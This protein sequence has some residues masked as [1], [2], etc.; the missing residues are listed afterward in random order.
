VGSSENPGARG[1][2]PPV[3]PT[4]FYVSEII[5]D[6]FIIVPGHERRLHDV[7]DDCRVRDVVPRRSIKR[8]ATIA[9][10]I[11]RDLIRF[12]DSVNSGRRAVL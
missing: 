10:D 12:A 5:L 8:E 2:S 1:L 7:L 6:L 9:V 11:Q 3:M 4:R